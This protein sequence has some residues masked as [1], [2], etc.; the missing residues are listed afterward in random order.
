MF[1]TY[2]FGSAQ[3]ANTGQTG[4]TYVS[5]S[6]TMFGTGQMD[7]VAAWFQ[8]STVIAQGS[9]KYDPRIQRLM[10]F[11]FAPEPK[12][13]G[14][15][16]VR[17]MWNL[18]TTLEAK[19]YG[20]MTVRADY[21]AQSAM[22]GTGV[23]TA[24][25]TPGF[26]MYTGFLAQGVG[27]FNGRG[28][29]LFQSRM[30]PKGVGFFVGTTAYK[31]NS[32]FTSRGFGYATF[33]GGR[34]VHSKFVAQG[35]SLVDFIAIFPGDDEAEFY[36]RGLSSFI[37]FT[38]YTA[39]S[40]FSAEG[41]SG[42]NFIINALYQGI[43]LFAADS[44]FIIR[45]A[46]KFTSV[47]RAPGAGTANF[48]TQLARKYDALFNAKGIGRTN[49]Q[50]MF[51]FNTSMKSLGIASFGLD[52]QFARKNSAT[53]TMVGKATFVARI[54]ATAYTALTARGE[55][56]FSLASTRIVNSTITMRGE[57]FTN[58]RPGNSLHQFLPPSNVAFDRGT[59]SF[60]FDWVDDMILG[61]IEKQPVERKD[62]DIDLN[63]WLK[64]RDAE[65][66]LDAVD[67]K[68][69]R[70]AGRLED[71]D[72]LVVEAIQLTTTVCKV[73]VSGGTDCSTYKV[74]LTVNTVRGRRDQAE[75]IFHVKDI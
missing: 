35:K 33:A 10:D 63:K 55:G 66:S 2:P 41:S 26:K 59:D 7:T 27:T 69:I 51:M 22:I 21:L 18:T 50:A 8:D 29:A 72:P 44:E 46:T 17:S 68:V 12:G 43:G 19:G 54:M 23:A 37:G 34:I 49:M 40:K 9:S 1:A 47:F 36:A 30:N 71:K 67:Y 6:M 11:G 61:R 3:F 65:D 39:E 38:Y 13:D 75:L 70:I 73:W 53:A 62:Y 42:T 58:F 25:F 16:N 28:A 74:E 32:T 64:Q 56:F 60:S 45:T 4:P 5:S 14:V 48:N 20:A 31:H 15:F 24:A 57:G 52:T